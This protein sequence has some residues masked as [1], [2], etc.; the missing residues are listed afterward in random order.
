SAAAPGGATGS[1]SSP[2]RSL[3]SASPLRRRSSNNVILTAM[4]RLDP[5]VA[6]HLDRLLEELPPA[7]T[8]PTTFLGGRFDAGLAWVHYPLGRGG[9]GAD[10]EQHRLVAQRLEAV[11]APSNFALNPIGLG[12]VGPT[13]AHHGTDEQCHR[14]LRRLF[15]AEDVWCQM[16]SEPGAGSD[17]AG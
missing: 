12:M 6:K 9:L 2:A 1:R 7:S 11:G 16:F 13:I 8:D 3:S 10:P 5:T 15:T 14:Y 4:T 17:L